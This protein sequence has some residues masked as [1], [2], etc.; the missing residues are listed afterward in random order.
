MRS[1]ALLGPQ[2]S[3]KSTIAA[4]FEEHRGYQRHGIAD[5]IKHVANLAYRNLSKDERFP[6]SRLSGEEMVTGR[7]LLQD[8]GAALRKVDTK[9]WLRVWRQDYFEIE[10]MG[11][12]VVVE[13]VRL[14]AEVAYLKL[15][16]PT[17]FVVRLTASAEVRAARRG[18]ELL[19]ADDITERGWTDAYADLTLD[20]SNL[21]PEDAYRVITDAM[22]VE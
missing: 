11:Y 3:G 8:I 4:L 1:I 16:E 15:V 22:E 14:D 20:T 13:D 17:I 2:G 19:G 10:R 12:G 7:E 21:S 6:V 18:G 5:A 9:F